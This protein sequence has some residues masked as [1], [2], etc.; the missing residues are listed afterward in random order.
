MQQNANNTVMPFTGTRRETLVET[1]QRTLQEAFAGDG[2]AML[3]LALLSH[4]N[5]NKNTAETQYWLK[6]AMNGIPEE[7]R[8]SLQNG[9]IKLISQSLN[10]EEKIHSTSHLHLVTN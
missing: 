2:D 9:I 5:L 1:F 4:N 8:T 6:A 7:E 10:T 3:T